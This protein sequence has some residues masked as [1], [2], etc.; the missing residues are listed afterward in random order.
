LAHRQDAA[1]GDVRVLE[2]VK[3]DNAIVG[4]GLGIIEDRAAVYYM[5]DEREA[6]VQRDALA[7]EIERILPSFAAVQYPGWLELLERFWRDAPRGAV[8]VLDEL[9]SIVQSSPEL[10]SILQKIVDRRGSQGTKLIV[11]GSSQRMMQGLVLD[12]SA[13]LYGRAEEIL[14]VEPLGLHTLKEAFGLTKPTDIVDRW[15]VWGGVPRYW[16]L[17]L[18]YEDHATAVRELVLD[19]MGVL[20]R[21]PDR[22]LLDEVA[23]ISLSSSILAMIGQGCHR[24]SEI[25]GRVGQPTTALSRPLLR[26]VELGFVQRELPYGAEERD[27]KRSIYRLGDPLLRFVFRF[28][29]PARSLLAESTQDPSRVLVGEAK[30][31][32]TAG[33][34]PR[35]VADLRRRAALCPPLAGKNLTFAVWVLSLAGKPR[36]PGAILIDPKE[37]IAAL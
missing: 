35:L 7:R 37:L 3:R 34:L 8:L 15:A 10:P 32:C 19:P 14:K 30:R 21:E 33:E 26:L 25:A 28:V 36:D 20:H 5:G 11:C 27:S 13:P 24:F 17:A 2:H 1:R 29:E 6:S 31:A 4:R 9:P 18:D 23:T 16:E 12:A 22:L